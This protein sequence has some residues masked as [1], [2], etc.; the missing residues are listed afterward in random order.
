MLFVTSLHSLARRSACGAMDCFAP[1]AIVNLHS[2][3]DVVALGA[4]QRPD[5][6]ISKNLSSLRAKNIPLPSSG[7]S[8]I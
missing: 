7:K 6:Q 4:T 1:L 2:N 8:V 5:G 3:D